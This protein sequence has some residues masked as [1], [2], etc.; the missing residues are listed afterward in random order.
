MDTILTI[1]KYL[2]I[3]GASITILFSD[4]TS[5][6]KRIIYFVICLFIYSSYGFIAG[7]VAFFVI[8]GCFLSRDE[9]KQFKKS[10]Y[11]FIDNSLNEGKIITSKNVGKIFSSIVQDEEARTNYAAR[12]TRHSEEHFRELTEGSSQIQLIKIELSGEVYYLTQ[13]ALGEIQQLTESLRQYAQISPNNLGYRGVSGSELV[14]ICR[15]LVPGFPF[16][17]CQDDNDTLINIDYLAYYKC[18]KCHGIFKNLTNYYGTKY[19][20]NCVQTVQKAERTGETVVLEVTP[21]QIPMS[22]D[23]A[24][25]FAELD[26]K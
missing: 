22:G 13:K 24:D 16:I 25:I 21:D 23:M 6:L 14:N 9:E 11:E 19:C 5:I 26:K 15:Q 12:V 3:F 20:S 7:A 8:V 18:S 2:C 1:V 17:T 10:I 4:A